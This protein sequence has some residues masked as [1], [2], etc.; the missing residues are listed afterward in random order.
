MDLGY[1]FARWMRQAPGA[2]TLTDG[3]GRT[4]TRGELGERL[5]RLG[6]ALRGLGLEPGERVA[7]LD[8]ASRRH[9]EMDY[10]VM[11]AGL[12]RVPL[13][14]RL[15]LRELVAQMRDSEARAL[16]FAP[17]HA[18]VAA[19]IAAECDDLT[20]VGDGGG[21]RDYEALLAA[22]RPEAPPAIDADQL[23]SLN[24]TG[25]TTSRPKAVMLT[26][27]GLCAVVHNILLGTR[28]A[29]GERVLNVRPLWP[30]SAVTVMASV[31]G[32]AHLVLARFDP[33]RL[34]GTV[35]AGAVQRMSLVPTQLVRWLDAGPSPRDLESLLAID[36]GAALIPRDTFHTAL[37]LLGPRIGVIYGLTEAP[38]TAYLEPQALAEAER[39]RR[40]V[41]SAGRELFGYRISIVG[42]DGTPAAT[43]HTG[44]IVIRGPHVMDGYWREPELTAASLRDG[45][46]VTGDLGRLEDDGYLYV[47]GR[48]KEVIR[49]GGRSIL[50]QEVE[51]A[52]LRHPAVAEAAVVGLPDR[53]W[54]ELVKAFV[55]LGDG[56]DVSADALIDH[57]RQELASFKKPKLVEI[58]PNL[59]KSHYGKVL[60]GALV[61]DGHATKSEV[62]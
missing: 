5:L 61:G 9:L 47:V 32:G 57:C 34:A 26:H 18:E 48:K 58:V 33:Q 55:V 10:G 38:W 30:I 6:S 50:P 44:E 29:P 11:A 36:V 40:L 16:I 12:V 35:R 60:K 27:R 14:P 41:Q 43:G 45:A 2:A 21:G 54:G 52:L 62:P 1:C 25:G 3:D 15:N 46:L 28:S 31:L 37:D 49:S 24:Y 59:P 13:D 8:G 53:E 51:H 23:A 19:A 17:R 56:E 20:L 4:W 42:E 39:R 7:L 22:A